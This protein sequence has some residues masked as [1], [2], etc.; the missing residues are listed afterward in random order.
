MNKIRNNIKLV[1]NYMLFIYSYLFLMPWNFFKAQMGLFTVVLFIWWIIKFKKVILLKLRDLI[2]FEPLI[3]LIVFIIFTYISTLWSDN[4]IAALSYINQF[5]KYYFLLIPILF[6]SMS[7]DEARNGLKIIILSF[8]TYAVFSLLIYLGIFTIEETRSNSNN[9]KGIMGY[10]IMSQYMAIGTIG[11]FFISLN[12]KCKNIKILFFIIMI[13]CFIGLFINNSRTAQLALILTSITILIT[14][15]R[16]YIF[17]LKVLSSILIIVIIIIYFLNE[18]GKINRY[19]SA[20]L[21]VDKIFTENKYTGS[22]GLRVYF[23]KAGIEIIKDNFFFGTGPEDNVIFLKQIQESDI[24]YK[25]RIFLS[26]HSEHIDIL[27]RYGFIGYTLLVLS[28]VYLL[29][30]L[31]D[32]KMDY[33]IGLSFFLVTFYISFANATFSKKPINYILVSVFVLLC[34]IAYNEYKEKKI[35][36]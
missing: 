2:K 9:P 10:A 12:S 17:N 29:Y 6:T 14:H 4:T 21:E 30:K 19:K 13:M 34:V 24:N 23:T 27:T 16:S 7:I 18:S 26:F 15:Y 8:G 36:K 35:I 28:I 1:D 11:A 33:F 5:H 3:I 31:K 32:M 20:Y 25:G 22:F